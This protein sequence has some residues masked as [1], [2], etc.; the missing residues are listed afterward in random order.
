MMIKLKTT[1]IY[2]LESD[3][4]SCSPDLAPSAVIIFL[5]LLLEN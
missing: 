3:R 2:G 1:E 4:S 5:L